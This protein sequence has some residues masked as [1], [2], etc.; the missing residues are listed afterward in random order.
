MFFFPNSQRAKN[1][2]V[3]SAVLKHMPQACAKPEGKGTAFCQST[4][5]FPKKMYIFV[6]ELSPHGELHT[7]TKKI[8]IKKK[9]GSFS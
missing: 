7:H 3:S 4:R 6:C 8:K 1:F 2:L 9:L 5:T